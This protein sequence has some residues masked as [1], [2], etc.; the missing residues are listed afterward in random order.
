MRRLVRLWES[1]G[2]SPVWI[3]AAGIFAV[4]AMLWTS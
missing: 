3:V 1:G 2:P 4:G